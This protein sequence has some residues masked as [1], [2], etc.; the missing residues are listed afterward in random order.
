[1]KTSIASLLSF[2]NN[3]PTAWH[4]VHNGVKELQK[5][6]FKE[7]KENEPWKLQAGGRYFV[8]R[9]GSSLCAFVLPKK[10]PSSIHLAAAHTDSPG[11]KLKP[12]A[13]FIKDNMVML[14]V[15]V[16]GAPLLTSWLNRDLG[17]AG[18]VIFK[19]KQS[20]IQEELVDINFAP[21][22]IPQLA[23]HIDRNVNEN[24]LVLNKQTHLAALA[25]IES[26]SKQ[27]RTPLLQRLLKQALPSIK[28]ILSFDLFLYPL[29]PARLLGASQ[30][31]I[32]SYRIDNLTSMHAILEAAKGAKAASSSLIKMAVFWDHEEIGSGSAQGAHSP[33]IPH[34]IERI[35]IAMGLS[36]EE[37][38]RLFH[39]SLCLS[40]DLTH[41]IHPSYSDKHEPQHQVLLNQ[42]IAIKSNAQQ[43][44]A[45]DARSSAT[46]ISLCHQHKIPL[47]MYVGRG[48]IACG[49]TVGPIHAT[50][51]GMPTVDVGCPQLSMHGCRE[52]M[53]T[54]DHLSLCQLMKAFL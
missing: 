50:S 31:L 19:N 5:E 46:I 30:E 35:A 28:D 17:I 39:N 49:T 44:Y 6:G 38:L 10:N 22:V 53:G 12:Q 54:Q 16:Y 34:V 40:A 47:Q 3:S 52:L 42:G 41:A 36:R 26:P 1:M 27:K 20:A 4:A 9:N 18:R 48:D 51:T 23:I 8:T 24:G 15:E 43:R 45:S 32:A 11:F 2:L 21:V 13:E 7:L 29:E 25:A 14:G 37:Y 33:F